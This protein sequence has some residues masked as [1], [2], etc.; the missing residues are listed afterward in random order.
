M[1][2]SMHLSVAVA[3]ALFLSSST[4]AAASSSNSLSESTKSRLLVVTEQAD[5]RALA[6]AREGYYSGNL[7]I[8][9]IDPNSALGE[10]ANADGIVLVSP[11]QSAKPG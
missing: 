11:Q 2:T 8:P 9:Y 1:T 6:A 7:C 5:F 4:A 10:Y 3:A